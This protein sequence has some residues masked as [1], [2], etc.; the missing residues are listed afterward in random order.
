MG[1]PSGVCGQRLEFKVLSKSRQPYPRGEA[2]AF[3]KLIISED[4]ELGGESSVGLDHD[5]LLLTSV[6][7]EMVTVSETK[8][9]HW[10]LHVY[11][12]VAGSD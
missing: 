12:G 11:G 10:L 9:N 3:I 5:G 8:P 4:V 1:G 6:I 2:W 7:L